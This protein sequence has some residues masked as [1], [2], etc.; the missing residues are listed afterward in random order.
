MVSWAVT[1]NW[2]AHP[3]LGCVSARTNGSHLQAALKNSS[4][5]IRAVWPRD[6]WDVNILSLEE[7]NGWL[8]GLGTTKSLCPLVTP[9]RG[10]TLWCDLCS[11]DHDAPHRAPWIKP[12]LNFTETT[13]FLSS[14]LFPALFP[15]LLDWFY[16]KSTLPK[17]HI[18]LNPCLKG[19]FQEAQTQIL[20]ILSGPH[21]FPYLALSHFSYWY[22]STLA[23]N[24]QQTIR[25]SWFI[26]MHHSEEKHWFLLYFGSLEILP[27]GGLSQL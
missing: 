4:W 17:T 11:R 3:S 6:T 15:F 26:V 23:F 2:L 16:L 1:I 18:H 14:L 13:C 24:L 9:Q 21:F 10:I 22:V 20:S 19:C 25:Y 27:W 12:K 5:L 8:L 7:A